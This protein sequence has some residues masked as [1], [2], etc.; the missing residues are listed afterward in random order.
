MFSVVGAKN[1]G[2]WK[3]ADGEVPVCF[4]MNPRIFFF[5]KKEKILKWYEHAT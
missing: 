4:A 2:M 1:Y 5:K 3:I